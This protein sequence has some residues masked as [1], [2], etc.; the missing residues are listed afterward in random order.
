MT[1][2]VTYRWLNLTYLNTLDV[3]AHVRMSRWN[4]SLHEKPMPI[5][6]ANR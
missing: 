4:G 1:S 6:E 5:L 3:Q 2:D